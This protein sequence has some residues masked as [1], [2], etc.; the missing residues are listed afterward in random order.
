[1]MNLNY[2]NILLSL[3]PLFFMGCIEK[4][5][6]FD[7]IKSQNWSSEWAIPL[8]NSSVSLKD[9]VKDS[10]ALIHDGEDGLLILVY[11]GQEFFSY[12][13]ED[14]PF[15]PNQEKIL[16]ENFIV[17]DLLPGNSVDV[18]VSFLYQ[19]ETDEPG[20]RI[21]SCNLKAG[22]YTLVLTTNLNK[23]NASVQLTLPGL[24]E[25]ATGNP[26]EFTFDI[27]YPVG[28]GLI[29]RDT[30]IDL[31]GHTLIFNNAPGHSNELVIE[32]LVTAYG[33]NNPNNSPYSMEL[34][35][36]YTNL[37]FTRSFGYIG[38]QII[39]MQDTIEMDIFDVNEEGNF[40]FGPGSVN[41]KIDVNNSFGIPILMDIVTFRAYHFGSTTDSVDIYIFGE[42]NPAQFNVDYP[43]LDQIGQSVLTEI[44]TE[45]SNIS[46]A[47]E[48]SSGNIYIDI[49]GVLNPDSDSTLTNFVLDTSAIRADVTVEMSLFGGISGF[50]ITDTVDFDL[51]NIEDITSLLLV[52]DA[53]NGY[54]IEARLQ[55]DFVDSAYQ[56]LHSLLPPWEQLLSAAPVGSP[57][58]YRVTGHVQKITNV[59]LNE[60]KIKAVQKAKKIIINASISTVNGQLVKIY[61][62]Y[63]IDL[64]I[65]ARVGINY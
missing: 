59:I 26:V 4:E 43:G 51:G 23:D 17:P 45:N 64:K 7:S 57:P 60:D 54:P 3:I 61:N 38:N 21:D 19:L 33:D 62:D 58:D 16:G 11:E 15:I 27:S 65:G 48:I 42:G 30:T 32:A 44:N 46:E 1:M 6:D 53:E 31:A 29:V 5:L 8:I 14:I 9:L 28:G 25:S 2:K 55:L 52:V 56:V 22:S 37:G 13:G 36:S 20:T 39:E 35:N 10:T 18:P 63:K 12:T 50:K 24:I 47:I 34:K 41:L 49:D 40:T